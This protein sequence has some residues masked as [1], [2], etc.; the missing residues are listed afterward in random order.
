MILNLKPVNSKVGGDF[1]RFSTKKSIFSYRPGFERF[2][3]LCDVV[4]CDPFLAFFD[5]FQ[6]FRYFM[7]KWGTFLAFDVARR[8]KLPFFVIRMYPPYQGVLF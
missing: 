4:T 6:G 1:H 7:A 5:F 8:L 3:T 2:F